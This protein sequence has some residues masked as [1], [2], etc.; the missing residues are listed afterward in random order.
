MTAVERHHSS[1]LALHGDD[2]RALNRLMARARIIANVPGLKRD[3]AGNVDAIAG[4]MLSL[5]AYGLPTTITGINSSFD[6]IEGQATPSAQLYQVLARRAGWE[7]RTLEETDRAVTIEATKPGQKPVRVTFKLDQAQA[8]HKLDEWVEQWQTSQQGKRYATRYIIRVN[9]EAVNEPWPDWVKKEVDRGYIK[10]FDAWWNYRP[11]MIWK[12]AAK[13]AVKRACPEVLLGDFGGDDTGFSPSADP[14]NGAMGDP[15]TA[16]SVRHETEGQGSSPAGGETHPD[17]DNITDA[18]V[19]DEVP[20][21]ASPSP[22]PGD[23]E[24]PAAT[25]PRP[26]GRKAKGSAPV[27][28]PQQ[29]QAFAPDP[30]RPF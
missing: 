10:R 11:D 7:L 4:I 2:Q 26:S 24:S 5:E 21:P 1:E 25:D 19:V 12:S 18:E 16:P 15:W 20:R 27:E 6:W 30:G 13:R 28:E 29:Q 23:A 17:D 14:P 22:A 3:I 9:G 8:S